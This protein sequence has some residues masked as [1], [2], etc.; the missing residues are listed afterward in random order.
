[1]T[2][3]GGSTTPQDSTLTKFNTHL[4]LSSPDHEIAEQLTWIEAELFSRIEVTDHPFKKST[5]LRTDTNAFSS[6]FNHS[7]GNS[8]E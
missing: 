7:R 2:S 6:P 5:S 8:C 3:S 4:L 1:M